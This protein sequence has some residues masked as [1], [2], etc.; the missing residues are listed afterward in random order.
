MKTTMPAAMGVGDWEN[1]VWQYQY[2]GSCSW[3]CANGYKVTADKSA[4]ESPKP[5]SGVSYKLFQE[6]GSP[7]SGVEVSILECFGSA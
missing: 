1:T 7:L 3:K 5:G 6:N 4:C 2:G